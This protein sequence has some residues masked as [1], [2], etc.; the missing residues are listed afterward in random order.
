MEHRLTTPPPTWPAAPDA[1]G[2]PSHGARFMPRW[3]VGVVLAML[4][5]LLA[6]LAGL[7]LA[8]YQPAQ[9]PAEVVAQ[10]GLSFADSSGGAVTVTDARSGQVLAEMRGE[11]G[12]LRGVLRGMAR[13]RRA[14]EVALQRPYVLSLREDGRLLLDDPETGRR[15]DLASFGPDNTAVFLRWLPEAAGYAPSTVPATRPPSTLAGA[16]SP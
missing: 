8:G 3:A 14:Q 1:G 15:I 5:G 10:R 11:Q 6:L 9:L 7:R 16:N 12:F 4:T 13:E 2:G